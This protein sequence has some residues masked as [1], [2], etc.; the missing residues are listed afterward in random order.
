MVAASEVMRACLSRFFSILTEGK[1]EQAIAA[2][3][4]TDGIDRCLV[5][6]LPRYCLSH[7]EEYDGK[8]AQVVEVLKNSE[9]PTQ[10]RRSHRN[11]GM[12]VLALLEYKYE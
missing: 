7:K 10:R 4:I 2:F 1:T 3:W 5:G 9:S 6:F 12:A 8:I 11:R